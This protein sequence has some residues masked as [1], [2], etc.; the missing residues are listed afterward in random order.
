MSEV[1]GS[2]TGSAMHGRGSQSY[3]VFGSQHSIPPVHALQ[4]TGSASSTA[5]EAGSGILGAGGSTDYSTG[6]GGGSRIDYSANL[7]IAVQAE[8]NST[9]NLHAAATSVVLDAPPSR[10]MGEDSG[11]YHRGSSSNSNSGSSRSARAAQQHCVDD[12]GA[13]MSSRGVRYPPVFAAASSDA[14][15]SVLSSTNPI[16]AASH[17][18]PGVP[19]HT[20]FSSPIVAFFDGFYSTLFQLDPILPALFKHSLHVQGRML[21]K[22]FDTLVRSIEDDAGMRETLEGLAR[23][24][25][26]YGVKP[27]MYTHLGAGVT[28][29]LRAALGHRYTPEVQD[30]WARVVAYLLEV[31]I[32]VADAAAR[33]VRVRKFWGAVGVSWHSHRDPTAPAVEAA[34]AHTHA[35]HTFGVQGNA[36]SEEAAAAAAAAVGAPHAHHAA[37]LH[38]AGGDQRST[39]PGPA[40]APYHA[41]LPSHALCM[42]GGQAGRRQS[43]GGGGGSRMHIL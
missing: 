27:S 24:H 35:M 32:P 17:H 14:N 40:G 4:L 41:S 22:M 31:I 1:M 7:E 30:A 37:A 36:H 15:I 21:I 25:A 34:A 6:G 28:A 3:V 26:L 29:G 10:L 23:R 33:S 5:G 11:H 20:I 9:R 42:G 19:A 8:R 39:G 18:H 2:S 38:D 16:S 12:L 43:G 13:P